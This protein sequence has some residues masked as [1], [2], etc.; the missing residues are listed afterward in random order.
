MKISSTSSHTRAAGTAT[1]AAAQHGLLIG[2]ASLLGFGIDHLVTVGV[3]TVG[4]FLDVLRAD[5]QFPFVVLVALHQALLLLITRRR[6]GPCRRR[7]E[8]LLD[9]VHLEREKRRRRSGQANLI[10]FS[11][12]LR[13]DRHGM[14]IMSREV[15]FWRPHEHEILLQLR[16]GAELSWP[17][18]K[19][20]L[21]PISSQHDLNF[22]PYI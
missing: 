9:I 15:V 13:I 1:T 2:L 16:I 22:F 5:E 14:G 21:W 20:D 8:H 6:C 11:E 17:M 7:H 12:R 10:P 19:Q 18:G 4:E 3:H